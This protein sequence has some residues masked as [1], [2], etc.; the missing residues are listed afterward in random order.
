MESFKQFYDIMP[1]L[2]NQDVINYK[3][4]QVKSSAHREDLI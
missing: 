1:I 3:Q 2:V 4:P